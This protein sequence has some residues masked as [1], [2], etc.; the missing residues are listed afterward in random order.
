MPDTT[1]PTT[2]W[3]GAKVTAVYA[4]REMLRALPDGDFHMTV[5][6]N[7]DNITA[8]IVYREDLNLENIAITV[9]TS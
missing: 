1:S 6:R 4:L 5:T 8:E 7:G 2:T 3:R 9:V